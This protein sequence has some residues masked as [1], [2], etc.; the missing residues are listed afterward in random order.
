MRVLLDTHTLLW[1][2]GG[3]ERLSPRAREIIE[4]GGNEALTSV[5]SLWEIAI[6]HSLGRLE[7]DRPFTE[8]IPSQLEANAIG[9]LAMELRHVAAVATLPFH[10]RD[11]FDRLLVAQALVEDLPII[12]RDEVFDSYGVKRIW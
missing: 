11:P 8:L 10:H 6:K 9:V 2:L 12:G 4:D 7:L 5:A 3:D 1:F